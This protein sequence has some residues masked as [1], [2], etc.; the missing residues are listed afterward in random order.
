VSVGYTSSKPTST[1]NDFFASMATA[2]DGS[3]AI[4]SFPN[5][6]SSS[7]AKVGTSGTYMGSQSAWT[8]GGPAGS[9]LQAQMTITGAVAYMGLAAAAFLPSATAGQATPFPFTVN[10]DGIMW[11]KEQTTAGVGYTYTIGQSPL[12][13]RTGQTLQILWDLPAAQ[14]AAYT[15]AFRVTAWFRYDPSA[16]PT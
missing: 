9:T 13:L 6:T 4:P 2:I 14:Y 10:V 3:F 7:V 5:T 1:A 15:G 8:L 16:Q 11:D 12:I